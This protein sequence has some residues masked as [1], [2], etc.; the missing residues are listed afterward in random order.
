MIDFKPAGKQINK[1]EKM[2]LDGLNLRWCAKCQTVKQ[3]SE[4][5]KGAYSCR[6]CKKIQMDAWKT[7][8]ID[9]FAD[10]RITNKES[11]KAYNQKWIAENRDKHR[12]TK[13]NY[14]AL[15]RKTNTQYRITNSL[16]C[17]LNYLLKNKNKIAPTLDLLGCSLGEFI[18][19][20]E[21]K[22]VEGMCWDNY[23]NPNGDHSDCWHIDHI[24]P[25]S[26]FD[27]TNEDEQRLCFHYSNM[28]PLWGID[29]IKKGS[30]I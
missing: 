10:Y 18:S 6:S 5:H 11:R 15:Q 13:K 4:F 21:R 24:K 22:F 26:S 3:P 23:G 9:Y 30:K 8:N 14:K 7:Q 1:Q 28:Q 19:H 20:L 2:F 17:R 29:N 27:L 12:E 25:C 16:R